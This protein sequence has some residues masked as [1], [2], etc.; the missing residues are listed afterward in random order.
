MDVS[1]FYCIL[2]QGNDDRDRRAFS[3]DPGTFFPILAVVP[4]IATG[5]AASTE[6]SMRVLETVRGS[7]GKTPLWQ[8]PSSVM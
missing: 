8:D 4:N 5:P 7:P 6:T 1:R 3:A 2:H